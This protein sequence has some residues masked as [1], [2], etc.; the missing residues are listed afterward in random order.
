MSIVGHESDPLPPPWRPETDGFVDQAVL[1]AADAIR[2]RFETAEPFKHAVVENFFHPALAEVLLRDF[3][4]FDPERAKN[5]F[6]QIGGKA[7]NERIETISG[8]YRHLAAHIQ[9]PEFLSL[10]GRLTG[11][12]D[13]LPDPN[14]YG[15]GTHEN[16]HG[17]ALDP[18][19][20][21]NYDPATK[22]HRRLQPA[23]L[24]QQGVARSVGR[25]DR[26]PLRPTSAGRQPHHVLH[27]GLQPGGDLRDQRA[28]L[29]WLPED[30][31]AGGQTAPVSQEFVNLSLYADAAGARDC[32]GA[33]H[34]LC[35][36][37][38]A[39]PLSSR[40]RAELEKISTRSRA[41]WPRATTGS[42][43]T[44]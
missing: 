40:P 2:S 39:Q 18:H 4:A 15:G 17:Q 14:L 34:F 44:R 38:A 16:R 43:G 35:S 10:V 27:A 30:H 24:S 32:A 1:A 33:W 22:L 37:P 21:F 13:L 42:R 25:V 20:D 28:F 19:V 9:S 41:C 12:S 5:E 11:I 6:G 31:P 7:V 3:P 23:R 26:A 29:A 8:A 36:A